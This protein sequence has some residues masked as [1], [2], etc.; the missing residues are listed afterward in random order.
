MI[1]G[2]VYTAN[3]TNRAVCGGVIKKD[4]HRNWQLYIL[5]IPVIAY[6][7][8]FCYKPMYGIIIAFKHFSP[9]MGIM[10]SPW[11]GFTYFKQFFEGYY[12]KRLIINTIKISISQIIFGFPMPII[13]AIL[14]NELR[15]IKVKKVIQ[16]VT[17]LPH[18]V[19]LVVLCG[20][21]IQLTD[22]NGVINDIAAFFGGERQSMILQPK[23][24]L[25]IYV[26]SDI[27][28][29]IGWDSIIYMAAITGVG[30]EQYE[31]ATID[32]AGRFT[33][34]IKITIPGIMPT[35]IILLLLRIGGIMNVGYEKVILLQNSLNMEVSDVI[36]SYVYRAGLQ[37]SQWSLSTAVGLFNSVIN[38]I[39]LCGANAVSRRVSET[40]LW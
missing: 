28:Q 32:G 26:I 36:L 16:T 27:W 1:N 7:L 4:F 33:K 25:P 17:Y 15:C 6:F 5:M 10:K 21:V 3:G 30:E 2:K 13:L 20:M 31:A 34:I 40:S 9:A 19:S 14:M 12:V 35:I 24:F 23:M 8:M 29:N 39:F 18:F 37:G 22:K 11:A 38:I